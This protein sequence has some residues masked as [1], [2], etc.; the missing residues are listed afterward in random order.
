MLAPVRKGQRLGILRLTLDGQ[1]LG[2]YPL[3]ALQDVSVAGIF[4]RAAGIRSG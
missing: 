2:D 3:V 1:P 4:G